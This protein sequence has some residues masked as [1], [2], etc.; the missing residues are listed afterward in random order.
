LK[1]PFRYCAYGL[2]IQSDFA[3]PELGPSRRD[4]PALSI[5][6]T[7]PWQDQKEELAEFADHGDRQLL[8]WDAVGRFRI[9]ADDRIEVQPNPGVGDELVALPLLGAVLATLLHRRGLFTLHASAVAVDGR[10]VA[11]LGD[12]GAGK[13]TTAAALLEAG[14]R[15]IADDIV[16]I[17]F[18]DA[19]N[20][21]VLSGFGHLKLWGES[22]AKVGH[23]LRKAWQLHPTIDKSSYDVGDAFIDSAVPLGRLYVLSRAEKAAI[24][25]VE[26]AA[27]VSSLLRFSYMGRF[28]SAGFGSRLT[29]HFRR[30]AMLAQAGALARLTIPHGLG[31]IGAAVASIEADLHEAEQA[32]QGL[33]DE[34]VT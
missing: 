12:K 34:S 22:A 2:E 5:T 29:E 18:T 27:A 25:P 11:L 1:A 28:G 19:S 10:A 8:N 31:R 33:T 3:L 4:P 7:T 30:S 32:P 16:A 26:P 24:E 13:S 15:F 14:H 6:R 23:T 20:P 9:T 17:D 21:V